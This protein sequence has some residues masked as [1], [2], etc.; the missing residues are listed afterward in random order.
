MRANSSVTLC[1]GRHESDQWCGLLR[2]RPVCISTL[3]HFSSENFLEMRSAGY[4][5]SYENAMP[6]DIMCYDGHVGL[7]MGDGTIVNAIDEAHGIGIC[8]A[9]YTNIITIRRMF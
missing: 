1:L 6:G 9:T 2:I 5:V 8:N 3:W 4:E 7:Y